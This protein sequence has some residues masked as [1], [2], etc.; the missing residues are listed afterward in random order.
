[1][2]DI[3][4]LSERGYSGASGKVMADKL[5]VVNPMFSDGINKWLDSGEE[6]DYV[7]AGVNL[8]DIKNK[9]NLTYAAAILSMDWLLREPDKA[10]Q[11]FEKG[12]R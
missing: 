3:D 9:F 1:M 5:S 2:I 7:I 10:K 4:K 11:S 8:K 12:I 6:T